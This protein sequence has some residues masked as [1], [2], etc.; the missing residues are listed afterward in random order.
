MRA[1]S[2]ASAPALAPR[3]APA[4]RSPRARVAR[5]STRALATATSTESSSTEA[6]AKAS[7]GDPEA[8]NTVTVK[9]A[10]GVR[11]VRDEASGE[12]GL[13][14]YED[15]HALAV[16]E[17]TKENDKLMADYVKDSMSLNT[18]ESMGQDGMGT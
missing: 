12:F 16:E 15:M 2:A 17:L 10:E 8:D 18:T 14:Y 7:S 13:E 9:S 3:R 1:V 5:R 11:L 6:S 4:G